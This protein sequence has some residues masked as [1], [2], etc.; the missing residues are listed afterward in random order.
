MDVKTK[1]EQT[2]VANVASLKQQVEQLN[3]KPVG[4]LLDQVKAPMVV[5]L[6]PTR[7]TG[8]TSSDFKS[9]KI[10]SILKSNLIIQQQRQQQQ[11]QQQF[12]KE[13]KS[14]ILAE[15]LKKGNLKPALSSTQERVLCYIVQSSRLWVNN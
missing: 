11:Q 4:S 9:K 12:I 15:T 1:S 14:E 2:S 3:T 6:P 10:S 7:V 5:D 8:L 13:A